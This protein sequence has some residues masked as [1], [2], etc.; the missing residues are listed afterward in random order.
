MNPIEFPLEC[1]EREN[2]RL[3]ALLL[4]AAIALVAGLGLGAASPGG[5]PDSLQARRIEILNEEGRVTAVLDADLT[6]GVLRLFTHE[7]QERIRMVTTGAGAE[8][9]MKS[10]SGQNLI[11]LNAGFVAGMV[12]VD[13]GMLQVGSK[14][15]GSTVIMGR[16]IR[17]GQ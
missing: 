13:A 2:R 17:E 5:V 12:R 14:N 4:L 10:P 15:L 8:L 16:T 6:G 1:L 7:G 11:A 3:R 9:E